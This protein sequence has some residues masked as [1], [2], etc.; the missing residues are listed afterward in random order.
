MRNLLK[1]FYR[2]FVSHGPIPTL[3]R[4][5]THFYRLTL[6]FTTPYSY[7]VNKGLME[8]SY[9]AYCCLHAANQARA[10]G[11]DTIS[12][13]E[14]GCAGGRGLIALEKIT[15]K[16]TKITG[17]NFEIYGFDT[18]EGLP[19]PVDYRDLPY[20]WTEGMFPMDKKSLQSKLSKSKIIFG[21]VNLTAETFI[22]KFK[23]APIGC[24][25]HDLD[26]YSSTRGSFKIFDSG[27]KHFLPRTFNYFD[28]IIGTELELYN[29]WSGERL[30]IREFNE[31]NE[32]QKFSPAYHLISKPNSPYWYHQI[33]IC[34]S[35]NHPD[36]NTFVGIDSC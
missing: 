12:A 26:Y 34:H 35:F 33:Y 9:Y 1:L 23:P 25:F 2:S 32:K 5:L 18:G 15:Q 8:R 7:Q 29:D 27:E 36:Y 3:V 14:F 4:T 13:I 21:D 31:Q 20:H 30:A 24:I 16:I 17:V 19:P 11:I 6:R 10:L 22:N 28:D